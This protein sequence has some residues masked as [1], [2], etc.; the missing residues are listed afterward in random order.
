MHFVLITL[1]ELN[2]KMFV[3]IERIVPGKKLRMFLF[4]YSRLAD[5]TRY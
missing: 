4:N 2:L 1:G 5:A 3:N